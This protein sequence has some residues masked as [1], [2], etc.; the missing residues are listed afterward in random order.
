MYYDIKYYFL[1]CTFVYFPIIFIPLPH[2][3]AAGFNIHNYDF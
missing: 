3:A 2:A 1:F